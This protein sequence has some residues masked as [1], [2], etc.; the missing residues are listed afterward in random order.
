[1]EQVTAELDRTQEDLDRARASYE[2]V[3]TRLND[4]AVA[5]YMTGPASSLDFLLNAENVAD[6][7]DRMAYVDALARSDAELAVKV[8]NRKNELTTLQAQ[9]EEQ[10][11][12]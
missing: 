7:T 9:L 4:R 3:S 12:A 11:V 2:R 10:Q 6:L 5:A 1:M 8:A